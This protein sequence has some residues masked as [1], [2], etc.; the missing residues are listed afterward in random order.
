MPPVLPFLGPL[1]GEGMGAGGAAAGEAF[2]GVG[3][4]V[5]MMGAVGPG[6]KLTQDVGGLQWRTQPAPTAHTAAPGGTL[7]FKGSAGTEVAAGI[8]ES[9]QRLREACDAEAGSLGP[10]HPVAVADEF[11]RGIKAEAGFPDPAAPEG[12][13]SEGVQMPNAGVEGAGF[14]HAAVNAGL[15]GLVQQQCITEDDVHFGMVPEELDYAGQGTGEVLL[16]RVEIS[17]EGTLN[18]VEGP[19]DGIIHAGIGSLENAKRGTELTQPVERLW[20]GVFDLGDMVYLDAFPGLFSYRC[21][22]QRQEVFLAPAG[23]GNAEGHEEE[24]SR[25]GGLARMRNL[26]FGVS[27]AEF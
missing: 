4:K 11:P 27:S 10:D 9:S 15:P 8:D 5:D 6:S 20:G 21:R 1:P 12:G 24:K 26:K 25:N 14:D 3:A 7:G 22:G 13:A 17:H 2:Q 23:G 16:I 19:V 18:T